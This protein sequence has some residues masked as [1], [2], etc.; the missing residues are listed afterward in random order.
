MKKVKQ[1]FV[2]SKN[3]GVA[4]SGIQIKEEIFPYKLKKNTSHNMRRKQCENTL[5]NIKNFKN[6]FFSNFF[7]ILKILLFFLFNF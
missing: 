7:E 2:F 1:K 4:K 5:E 6:N 3:F